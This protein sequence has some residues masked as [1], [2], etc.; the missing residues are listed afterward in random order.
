MFNSTASYISTNNGFKA[1]V[2]TAGLN[3][4]TAFTKTAE[5][6]APTATGATKVTEEIK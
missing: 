4:I 6:A 2:A 1:V 5:V 3:A